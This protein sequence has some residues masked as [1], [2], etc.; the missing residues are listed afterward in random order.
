MKVSNIGIQQGSGLNK[1]DALNS[2]KEAKDGKA[3]KGASL[4]EIRS[5]SKVDISEAAQRLSKA[6]EI[7]SADL[8]SVDA[9]NVERLQ[10]LIDAGSYKV[11]ADNIASKLVDEH[12]LM[13]S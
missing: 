10:K 3:H 9:K 2:N 5:S 4:G 11:S 12:L 13:P 7:A 1:S 8:N 6:K